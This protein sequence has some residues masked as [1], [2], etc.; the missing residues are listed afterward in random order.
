MATQRGTS[1]WQVATVVLLPVVAAV[2][3]L[4]VGAGWGRDDDDEV[5]PTAR[6]AASS[7]GHTFW[8]VRADGTPVRWDP[9]TPIAWVFDPSDAPTY[10]GDLVAQAV[11]V[12]A[13]TSGLDFRRLP[14]RAETPSLTRSLVDTENDVAWAPVLITWA[15]PHVGDVPL[16]TSDRAVSVPVSVDGVFVTGQIVLN[17]ERDDLVPVLGDRGTSW[18]ATLVHELGHLVGLDHVDDPDQLMSRFPGQGPADF[19]QGDLAGLAQ[20]GSDAGDCL[21]PGTPREIRVQ[22][23]PRS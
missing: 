2:L 10:G 6:P 12:M 20:L 19:G 11:D 5:A 15:S 14:D 13:S 1:W 21:D 17:A 22:V 23:E 4:A 18:G 16:R 8:D 7:E 9:C 3:L